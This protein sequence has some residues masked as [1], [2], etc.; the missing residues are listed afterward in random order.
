ML[1]PHKMLFHGPGRISEQ[2]NCISFPK[3]DCSREHDSN[4]KETNSALKFIVINDTAVGVGGSIGCFVIASKVL[5]HVVVE[6]TRLRANLL[7]INLGTCG[8]SI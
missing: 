7:L 4:S 6:I 8:L 2:P 3:L 1:H 5:H